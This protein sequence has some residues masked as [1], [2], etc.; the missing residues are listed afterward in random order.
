M[1]VTDLIALFIIGTTVK[2][3]AKIICDNKKGKGDK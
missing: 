3:V 1:G 2:G